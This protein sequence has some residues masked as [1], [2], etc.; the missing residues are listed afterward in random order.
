MVTE[1]GDTAKAS[2][3]V[4]I[5]VR[6]EVHNICSGASFFTFSNKKLDMRMYKNGDNE[7]GQSEM[8]RLVYY[9]INAVKNSQ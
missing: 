3:L 9:C 1:K 5:T 4:M 7:Y 6:L 2:I 8:R